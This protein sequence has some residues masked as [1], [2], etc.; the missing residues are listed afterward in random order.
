MSISQDELE[1]F[2]QQRVTARRQ[3]VSQGSL[4]DKFNNVA[5]YTAAL[6][7]L[8]TLF[9]S[10]NQRY[11]LVPRFLNFIWKIIVFLIPSSLIFAIDDWRDPTASPRMESLSLH[12]AKT[13]AIKRIIGLDSTSGMMASVYQARKRAFSVTGNALGLK[14][15]SDSPP[16][17]GNHDNSCYQNSILQGLSSLEAFPKYLS[18]CVSIPS[19]KKNETTV[20][21]SLKTLLSDLNDE[22]NRGSTLWTP[23][24]L[25]SMS[26]WTQ[27]DAQEYYSKILDDIDKG[28]SQAIRESKATSGL[29]GHDTE[30]E[31]H[32]K[33][34]TEDDTR[35]PSLRNPL[36]G[37]L[38]QRVACVQCGHSDGL[39][40]I[41]FNCLTLSLGLDK[42][43]HDIFERM[44]AYTKME[45]IDGVECPKC[46]LLKAQRLLT[47]LL[48]KMRDNGTAEEQLSE[49]VRR[50]AAVEL[51]L[52]EDDF[53]EAT[54]RDE[55][56]ITAQSKVSST[57]TKQIVIG[58]PPTNLVIHLNRSVFDPSTFNMMKNSAPVAFPTI[59]EL[60]PW[61]LGSSG[62]VRRT[63]DSALTVSKDNE[64]YWQMDPSAPMAASDFTPSK[65]AGPT[66]ELRAAVTHYGRHENGH[67]IC[68]R[69]QPGGEISL[70]TKDAADSQTEETT[71]EENITTKEVT[72]PEDITE[73]TK[74]DADSSP[75]EQT[76][77]AKSAEKT[78]DTNH[79]SPEHHEEAEGSDQPAT[80]AEADVEEG[81]K[82]RWWRL[83]DHN[84]SEVEEASLADLAPGVFM[85]FYECVEPGMVFGDEESKEQAEPPVSKAEASVLE[86][87]DDECA[88]TER[89]SIVSED[90]DATLRTI[91]T[92]TDDGTVTTVTSIGDDSDMEQFKIAPEPVKMPLANGHIL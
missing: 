7:L 2:Y 61:C 72:T 68:Y 78:A 37:L 91:D 51:A 40:F 83:S 56:K 82:G 34:D 10:I 87:S 35:A 38:A 6:V 41:P 73:G 29:E 24:I 46:T 20:A 62:V 57:K 14:L 88:L 65:I 27:Q 64:E 45:T 49:P 81:T 89:S 33:G 74:L 58:R 53:D 70:S 77:S 32:I 31:S 26:S 42:N 66:Y 9:T 16:G 8:A 21:Q 84:V 11:E 36:E 13:A 90:D 18:D 71:T 4:R 54:L 1:T 60:G 12:S 15:D 69:R 50:L 5:A 17:L 55:C 44:D 63:F 86:K 59:F 22:S 47:K 76:V 75:L 79:V 67:Y 3:L 85:L 52:E 92:A 48:E 25:K 28:V 80:D 23:R 19:S 43:R 39:S 30:S